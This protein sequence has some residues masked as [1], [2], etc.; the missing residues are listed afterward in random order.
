MKNIDFS[1][2][3][4]LLQSAETIVIT[5]HL[6]PDGDAIGSSLALYQYAVNLGKNAHILICGSIVPSNLKF[7]N[8][9]K[10]VKKYN[11]DRHNKIIYSADVVFL[12]DLNDT[13]RIKYME[14]IITETHARKVIIDHHISQGNFADLILSNPEASS[15]GELIY[16]FIKQAKCKITKDIAEDLYTAIHTDTGGFRFSSTTS[17]IHRIISELV[18][19]GANPEYIYDCI[20]NQNS[21]EKIHLQGC[22]ISE[23]QHFLNGNLSMIMVSNELLKKTNTVDNDTE[24]LS[25]I[26]LSVAGAKVG[27]LLVES[28]EKREI[29]VSI[30]S[31]GDI[32]VQSIASKYG[33]GGHINASGFRLQETTIEQAIEILV[34]EVQQ[35][36]N[37]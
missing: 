29:R 12:L 19:C 10:Q 21:K 8:N 17:G 20:Y 31:K 27:A 5:S 34:N 14:N 28:E 35:L 33:G 36:L 2:A 25:Q 37:L 15:T 1:P 9:S 32:N 18:D 11:P 4:E 30:R 26:P 24:G 3:I 13:S 23:M 16:Y 22:A 6:N 7:L